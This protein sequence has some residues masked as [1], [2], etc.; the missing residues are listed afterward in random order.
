MP[1]LRGVDQHFCPPYWVVAC[2]SEET[3][4]AAVAAWPAAAVETLS[5]PSAA[6]K[7]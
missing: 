5:A 7:C 4:D 1:T 3:A 6:R 2:A